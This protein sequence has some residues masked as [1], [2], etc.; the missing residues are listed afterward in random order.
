VRCR[1]WITPVVDVES[2]I[3][4]DSFEAIDEIALIESSGFDDPFGMIRPPEGRAPRGMGDEYRA[5][6]R[7]VERIQTQMNWRTKIQRNL[8]RYRGQSG[9][10]NRITIMRARLQEL[11]KGITAM[12]DVSN[13]PEG[14]WNFKMEL[15]DGIIDYV[16]SV[17]TQI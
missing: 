9:Q 3:A 2:A 10:R 6:R 17:T 15:V 7:I 16:Q 11:D 8:E 14:D 1:C 12:L 4:D 13:Q 5:R